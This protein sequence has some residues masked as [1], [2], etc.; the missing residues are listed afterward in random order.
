MPVSEC[1]LASGAAALLATAG[2][3]FVTLWILIEL[4]QAMGWRP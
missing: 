2:A 4:A 3:G 1:R